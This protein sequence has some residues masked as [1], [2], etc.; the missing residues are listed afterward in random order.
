MNNNIKTKIL[1]WFFIF[2]SC[3]SILSC[4]NENNTKTDC[5]AQSELGLF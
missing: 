3:I 1:I 2:I 4:K 5:S